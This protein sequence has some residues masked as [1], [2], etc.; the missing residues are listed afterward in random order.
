MASAV[1]TAWIEHS[2]SPTVTTVGTG[3]EVCGDQREKKLRSKTQTFG[4]GVTKATS[5]AAGL[6]LE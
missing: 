1:K 6:M 2:L 3:P 4:D 5:W